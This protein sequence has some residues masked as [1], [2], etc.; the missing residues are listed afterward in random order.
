[1]TSVCLINCGNQ[2][3]CSIDWY[4]SNGPSSTLSS[5]AESNDP[6]YSKLTKREGDYA[7]PQWKDGLPAATA[8]RA[9]A[10]ESGAESLY[11]YGQLQ[12]SKITYS[13]DA[14]QSDE[15]Q[16]YERISNLDLQLENE[17]AQ[18]YSEPVRANP[19]ATK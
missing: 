17:E 15:D 8:E 9:T 1:M 12:P 7:Q 14:V 13:Q 4:S 3:L 5:A 19:I 6:N 11:L 18:P 2:F 10:I 16:I